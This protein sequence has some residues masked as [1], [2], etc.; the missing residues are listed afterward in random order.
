MYSFEL[1]SNLIGGCVSNGEIM[2][3][4]TTGSI[5]LICVSDFNPYY[6]HTCQD[7]E[8]VFLNAE[9]SGIISCESKI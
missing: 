6:D 8:A 3:P 7:N 4:D 2:A 9:L 1:K 5:G